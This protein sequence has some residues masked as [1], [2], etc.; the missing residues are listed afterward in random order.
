LYTD[1]SSAGM[2]AILS[3]QEDGQE[4]V[5]AF[6][7]RSCNAA[8]ANNS[9]YEDDWLA[10]MWAI[11]HFRVY[12]KGRPFTLVTDHQTLLWLMQ[13]Q[14]LTGKNARWEMKLHKYKFEVK[15]HLGKTMQYIDGL[16]WNPL[17]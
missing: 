15:H 9:S 6:A 17:L 12:L 14:A 5:V 7:S 11:G 2:G 3:Q 1:S 4:R 13:N 8:E 10:T 16:S